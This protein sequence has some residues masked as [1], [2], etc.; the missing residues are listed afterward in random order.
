MEAMKDILSQFGASPE[1][2]RFEQTDQGLI[3]TTYFVSFGKQRRYVLQKINE[4]VFPN[5]DALFHNLERTLPHLSAPNYTQVEFH[6]TLGSELFH[7]T[8]NNELW[9]LMSYLPGSKSFHHTSDKQIAFE[10]GRILGLF[11]TQVN[12]LDPNT[13]KI[14]LDKFHNLD[15]RKEQYHLAVKKANVKDLERTVDLQKHIEEIGEELSKLQAMNLPIRVC[16]ND[17]KLNNILFSE[18]KKA[19]C[20]IDLDTLMPGLLLYDFGDAVRTLANPAPEEETQLSKIDFSIEMFAAFV[21]G[22]ALNRSVFSPDEIKSLSLG[23][24]YMP[25]LHG[26][27]AYTDFLMGNP[28]YKVTYPDQNL[29]RARSLIHFARLAREHTPEMQR[30]LQEKMM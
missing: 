30:I 27:R 18:E 13:L 28:Y 16:H 8:E 6:R 14:T 21:E 12:N 3:N 11:H 23:P 26:L 4:T 25:F 19:L 24:V 22:L 5:C 9:R 1:G 17:T 29:D 10:A 7:R 20:L 2:S 15:W